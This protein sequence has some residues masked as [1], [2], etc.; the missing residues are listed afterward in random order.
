MVHVSLSQYHPTQFPA[1]CPKCLQLTGE[2]R[3]AATVLHEPTVIRLTVRCTPCG[4]EWLIDKEAEMPEMFFEGVEP[5]E[6]L[7]H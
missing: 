3:A 4:H 6:K 7:S 5:K 2:V 1:H